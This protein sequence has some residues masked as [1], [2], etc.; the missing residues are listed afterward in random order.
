MMALART[1]DK[2][3]G[4][5]VISLQDGYT[6]RLYRWSDIQEYLAVLNYEAACRDKPRI[7]ELGTRKGYS[8]MA[9]LAGTVG[10]GGHV[11]SVDINDVAGDPEGM[12]IWRK[13]PHWTFIHGDDMDPDVQAQL[14]GQVDVLFIDTSHEYEHTL[15]ELRVFMPKVAAGGVALMHDTRLLMHRADESPP[16]RRALDEWCAEA[17]ESWDELPGQYGM[18]V[19][20]R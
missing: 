4:G 13:V 17:G 15:A 9:F 12:F 14:P 18:G 5:I 2:D 7:L 1:Y 3:R 16:V 8:T 6:D 10:N 20:R 11:W 19:I